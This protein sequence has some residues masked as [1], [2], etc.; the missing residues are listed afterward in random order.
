M[1]RLSTL[2]RLGLCLAAAAVPAAAGQDKARTLPVLH[3][4]QQMVE[5]ARQKNDLD[6]TNYRD[7]LAFIL[8]AL[9]DKVKVYPTENYYYFSFIHNGIRY[10]GNL[11][12]DAKERDKGKVN[13]AYFEEFT[14][15]Y[16]NEEN[17]YYLLG[18]EDGVKVEKK[19]E[20]EYAITFRGRTVIFQL[21]DLRGVKPPPGVLLEGETYI[22]P[23]FDESGVGFYL[24]FNPKL[25]VFHFILNEQMPSSDRLLPTRV[26]PRIVLGQRTGF[27]YYRDKYAP[28]KILIGIYAG[29]SMVNNYYDG[30]FDQLPDNFIHDER[31]RDAILAVAPE[32][33]G[34]IDRYGNTPDGKTRFLISPYMHYDRVEELR[35]F[36]ECANSREMQ[37][38]QYHACF[39]V[40]TAP[41][42]EEGADGPPPPRNGA[43]TPPPSQNGAETPPPRQNGEPPPAATDKR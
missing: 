32:M 1:I 35:L 12:L 33:K 24:V 25:K 28:R 31:L 22:G 38:A 15:W 26:S 8:N 21:N 3:T 19:A 37:R 17:N 18:P 20:L 13:F 40:A 29:N 36:A 6:I 5:A 23:V 16:I 41:G 2:L 30:P 4:N 34:R 11:R 10:A 7:V 43:D 14:P 39:S 42:G 27:A 9:P